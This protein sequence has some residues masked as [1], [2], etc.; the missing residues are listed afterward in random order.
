MRSGISPIRLTAALALL[1]LA[2]CGGRDRPGGSHAGYRPVADLPVR[3]GPPYQVRGRRHVPADDRSYSAVGMASWYG[4]E[5][6]RQTANGERFRPEGISAAH[7]TLPLP[8]YVEVTALR[9]GRTILVRVNDRGPFAG[10][11][12]IDLSRGAARELGVERDGTAPVQVRRVFPS[13][14]DRAALR[15]GR[16]AAPRTAM[17]GTER[18]RLL[19]RFARPTLAPA[20]P[21][22]TGGWFV[23]VAT[24]SDPA[25]AA[26][27]AQSLGG[28]TIPVGGY[29]Q[30]RIG[31]LDD[32]QAQPALARV[33]A[34]GYQDARLVRSDPVPI[35]T[36]AVR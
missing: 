8:A 31:P 24:F 33:R 6:G 32:G 22:M 2:A 25:R 36:E 18:R 11:R 13:D 4:S 20:D 9:T 12:I 23:Q 5:S 30:V 21:V 17:D 14:A 28:T 29:I 7:R 10:D 35:V 26:A 34:S 16:P 15:A 3:I 1:L 27:L 19:A